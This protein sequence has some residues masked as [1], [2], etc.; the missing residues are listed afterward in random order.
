MTQSSLCKYFKLW[1]PTNPLKYFASPFLKFSLLL[2]DFK[3]HKTP[4]PTAKR[5]IRDGFLSTEKV[6]IFLANTW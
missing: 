3:L 6:V 1:L 4:W 2:L 5:G